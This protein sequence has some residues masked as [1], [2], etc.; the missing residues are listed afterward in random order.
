MAGCV[1]GVGKIVDRGFR[2]DW[3]FDW[4]KP[5]KALSHLVLRIG[6]SD[7]RLNPVKALS[8]PQGDKH[9]HTHTPVH[10]DTYPSCAV[11]SLKNESTAH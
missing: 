1:L 11:V 3:L 7:R 6:L 2:C 10:T 5:G 4:V 9:T 8:R